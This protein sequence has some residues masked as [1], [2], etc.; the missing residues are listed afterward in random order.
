[1]KNLILIFTIL[2]MLFCV[3][4]VDAQTLA[5]NEFT[6]GVEIIRLSTADSI[7]YTDNAQLFCVV[8]NYGK[9]NIYQKLGG[10][11]FSSVPFT[12]V[13]IN[14]SL[15]V[16][17]QTFINTINQIRAFAINTCEP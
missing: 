6:G 14:D 8:D 17:R 16:D 3:E 13:S 2:S 4:E 1:M 10:Q 7:L 11:I 15:Y 5:V 12:A 9:A